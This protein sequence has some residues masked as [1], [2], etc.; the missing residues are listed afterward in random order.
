[1]ALK[2][3]KYIDEFAE[4]IIKIE[5]KEGQWHAIFHP[6]KTVIAFK[7]KDILNQLILHI[8]NKTIDLAC[9]SLNINRSLISNP[10]KGKRQKQDISDSKFAIANILAARF[11]DK[12]SQ[13]VIEKSLGWTGH[14]M[15]D[16]S[17]KSSD[18]KEIHEKIEK[19]YRSHPFL[20]N[21]YK[22]MK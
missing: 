19:I 16:Y 12:I 17:K 3:L 2:D 11:S 18:I 1:M 20:K 4:W 13:I 22:N 5:Y 21:G 8:I 9:D 15:L 6:N 14:G 7:F 10:I